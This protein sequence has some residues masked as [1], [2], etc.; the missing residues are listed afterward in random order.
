MGAK[1]GPFIKA[2]KANGELAVMRQAIGAKSGTS[3]ITAPPMA[4]QLEAMKASQEVASAATMQELQQLRDDKS[5]M[6]AQLAGA[7]ASAATAQAAHAQSEQ[8][9][10]EADTS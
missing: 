1:A 8:Q 3:S 4:K 9:L 10:S 2:S 5:E 7:Q 6:Q